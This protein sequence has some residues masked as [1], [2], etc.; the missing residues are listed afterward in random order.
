MEKKEELKTLKDCKDLEEARA[1]AVKWV[2]D[3]VCTLDP[4]YAWNCRACWKFREFFNLTE[5][6]LADE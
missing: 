5:E 2:K 4:K 3:C 6:D 1:L